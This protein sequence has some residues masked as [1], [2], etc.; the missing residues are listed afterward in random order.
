MLYKLW[1]IQNYPKRDV[2]PLNVCNQGGEYHHEWPGFFLFFIY[3]F[4]FTYLCMY[5]FWPRVFKE[6]F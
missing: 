4:I 6:I 1:R 2:Q 3:L 5:L